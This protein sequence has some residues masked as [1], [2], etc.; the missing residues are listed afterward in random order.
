MAETQ[1]PAESNPER[2]SLTP[3]LEQAVQDLTVYENLCNSLLRHGW[4][5]Y[6]DHDSEIEL[7]FFR[8]TFG[9]QDPRRTAL[10]QINEA[11]A[12][13]EPWPQTTEVMAANIYYY[14]RQRSEAEEDQPLPSF[15]ETY[16][17]PDP[18]EPQP[19]VSGSEPPTA[20]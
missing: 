15:E 9:Y 5:R 7:G 20:L 6:R 14:E 11:E 3:N 18:R 19:E 2:K 1:P 12:R 13:R 8:D 16:G 4:L 17:Y 10:H